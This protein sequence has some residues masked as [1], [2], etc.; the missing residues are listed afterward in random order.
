VR[1]GALHIFLYFLGEELCIT[2]FLDVLVE[3]WCN[4]DFFIFY[5]YGVGRCIIDFLFSR[6]CGVLQICLFSRGGVVYYTY[7]YFLGKE[8]CI[9]DFFS[10]IGGVVYY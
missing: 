5:G 8:L 1:S 10:S 9:T 6:G 2:D 7:F 3:E 4:T